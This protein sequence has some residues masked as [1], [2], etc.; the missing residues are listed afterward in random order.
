MRILFAQKLSYLPGL[1]GASRLGRSL[2]EGLAARNHECRVV[3]LAGAPA[4]ESKQLDSRNLDVRSGLTAPDL[5][6]A[7][8]VFIHNGVKV[9]AFANPARLHAQLN[10]QIQEFDPN[11]IIISEDPT[12]MLIAAALE[13]APRRTL[14]LSQSQATLP[15]GP[16]A[17]VRDPL[18]TRMLSDVAGILTIS[19]YLKR[20]IQRWAGLDAF[21]TA[22]P[23]YG[24]P[25]FA[26]LGSFGNRYVTMINPSGIK[27]AAI[28]LKLARQFPDMQFAAVPTWATTAA[29]RSALKGL[30][31]V[32]VLQ[33]SENI[34]DIFKSTRVLL[35]PSL[36]GEAFGLVVVEAM[37]RGIPV[38]ASNV[39]GLVEAKLGVDYTLPV[40]R[41]ENYENQRDENGIPIPIISE[42][43][44]DPWDTALRK[45]LTDKVEF[46]RL[47]IAS[48]T[49]A[50][51]YV[52]GLSIA[53]TERYLQELSQRKSLANS[54]TKK[55]NEFSSLLDGLTTDKLEIIAAHLRKR[56]HKA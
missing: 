22:V 52:A 7:K 44:V 2:L 6:P 49:A 9:F 28:F 12:C 18:R 34:D 1:N 11:W 26:D 38:L 13:S 43:D 4:K 46:D 10:H 39:G 40:H 23:V 53:P 25:P 19:Q 36:W 56:A 55:K 30:P 17:F 50:M 5:A 29:D 33:P 32:R 8:Q 15:F 3:A 14:F 27:G 45:V 37:L 21:V 16:D 24:V 48:K 51:K 31:N 20:Y 47:S 35:V 41:I 54:R 42:Q